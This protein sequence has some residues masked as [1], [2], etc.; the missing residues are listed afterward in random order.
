ML[1]SLSSL[2]K[3]IKDGDPEFSSESKQLLTYL[4]PIKTIC[5]YYCSNMS[6]NVL[7]KIVVFLLNSLLSPYF[8]SYLQIGL[9]CSI[10]CRNTLYILSIY[11]CLIAPP[12]LATYCFKNLHISSY[13]ISPDFYREFRVSKSSKNSSNLVF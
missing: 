13:S 12:S 7:S 10:T 4:F 9:T 8:S 11:G 6:N 5:G 2:G 1:I 3:A